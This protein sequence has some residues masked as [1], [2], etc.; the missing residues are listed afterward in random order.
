MSENGWKKFKQAM[1]VFQSANKSG[2]RPAV[3]R[4]KKMEQYEYRLRWDD[5]RYTPGELMI[6]RGKLGH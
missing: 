2:G 4:A 1:P 5:A 6:V 3:D